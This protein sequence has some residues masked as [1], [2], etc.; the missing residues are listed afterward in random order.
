MVYNV[1]PKPLNSSA[2]VISA[3]SCTTN[4]VARVVKV[5]VEEFGVKSGYMRTVQWYTAD[6]KVEDARDKDLRRGGGAAENMVRTSTGAAKGIG[7]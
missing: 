1:N 3:A 4:C 7:V 5:L 6:E 2:R